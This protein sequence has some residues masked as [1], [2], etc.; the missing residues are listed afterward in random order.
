M[1]KL[2]PD[3]T[4]SPHLADLTW[5]VRWAGM[6]AAQRRRLGGDL[7]RHGVPQLLQRRLSSW[8]G[9][10]HGDQDVPDRSEIIWSHVEGKGRPSQFNANLHVV[11]SV[12]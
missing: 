9:Q 3:M 6:R 2:H 7:R 12:T 4:E 11:T 8:Q 10:H 1:E 5:P